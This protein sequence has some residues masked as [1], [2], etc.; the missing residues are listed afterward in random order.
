MFETNDLQ[1][2]TS[3][4]MVKGMKLDPETAAGVF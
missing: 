3:N 4:K 1:G 2:Q